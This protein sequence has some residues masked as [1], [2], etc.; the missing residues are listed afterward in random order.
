VSGHA[1]AVLKVMETKKGRLL[2]LRNPWGC[3]SW[4]T[5][6]FSRSDKDSWSDEDFCE[7]VGYNPKLA[8]KDDGNF[9]ISWEDVLIYFQNFHLSWNPLLF[10]YRFS[11]H[12]FWPVSQ[13]P[14]DD[15]FNVGDNP[16]YFLALSKSAIQRKA[17]IWILVSRHVT[18]QEQEGVEAHDFLTVHVHRNDAKKRRVWYPGRSGKCILQG[19]YTNN[20]HV[21][22]RFDVSGPEDAFLSLVLSQ[23]NKTNDLGYTLSCYSTD[24]FH[25]GEAAA[26]DLEFV[27]ERTSAWTEEKSGGPLGTQTCE[28]NPSFAIEVP[29]RGATLQVRVTTPKTSAV[30]AVLVPVGKYGDGVRSSTGKPVLDTGKY[31]H[32]FLASDT[33]RVEGGPYVLL[34]SNFHAG[35]HATFNLVVSS[36]AK[37]RI[38]ESR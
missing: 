28:R 29:G 27:Y 34:V 1:Y 9:F 15:T 11:T 16:Q 37:I 17:T 21:L 25:L 36:S 38:E 23:Y 33:E 10:A 24:P 18:R 26:K 13:G 14:A 22:V 19:A 35:Q 20:P 3:Q 30:N 8:L 6:R 7:E 31:R 4:S 12:G 2:M 32:G 5:G